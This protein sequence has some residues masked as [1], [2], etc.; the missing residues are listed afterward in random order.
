MNGLGLTLT[1]NS[2]TELSPKQ[3]PNKR[4]RKTSWIQS[5]IG[6]AKDNN[7]PIYPATLDKLLNLFHHPTSL[8]TKS[9]PSAVESTVL[10][11]SPSSSSSGNFNKPPIAQ[12]PNVSKES[13]GMGQKESSISGF[14]HSIVSLTSHKKEPT[15]TTSS[16]ESSIL[17]NISPENTIEKSSSHSQ[18]LLES[19]PKSIK[20][21]LKENISPENTISSENYATVEQQKQK[22]VLFLVGDEEDL[23]VSEDCPANEDDDD[24]AYDKENSSLGDITRDSM[25]ILKANSS[26]D[27]KLD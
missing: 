9:S 7:A 6:S 26:G 17:Q 15:T 20:K 5:A 23:S 27:Q 3:E 4:T 21:E 22:R 16:S 19:L 25:T 1:T 18:M 24:V 12:K 14:I 11:S 13:L 2:P 10:A 8:F